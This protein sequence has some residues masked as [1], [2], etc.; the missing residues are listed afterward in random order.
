VQKPQHAAALPV[1]HPHTQVL[2]VL[3]QSVL[4]LGL[5]VLRKQQQ[6]QQDLALPSTHSS[7]SC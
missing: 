7:S 1:T 3:V 2:L 6:Q 5:R 4:V